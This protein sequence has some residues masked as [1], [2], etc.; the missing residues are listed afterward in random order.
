M[1][2]ADSMRDIA[3]KNNIANTAALIRDL[4]AAVL[5][6]A[7]RGDDSVIVKVYSDQISHSKHQVLSHFAERGFKIVHRVY[8]YLISWY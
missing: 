6:A 2:T 5:A 1:I 3:A 4:E 8:D 7:N